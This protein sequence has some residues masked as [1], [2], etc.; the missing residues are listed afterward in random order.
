MVAV[1][2]CDEDGVNIRWLHI[3]NSQQLKQSGKTHATVHQNTMWSSAVLTAGFN[4][5]GISRAA[6]AQIFVAEHG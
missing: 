1:L 6:A 2:M 5:S 3:G 4:Q